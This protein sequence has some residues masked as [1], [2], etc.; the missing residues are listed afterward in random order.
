MPISALLFDAHGQDTPLDPHQPLPVPGDDQLLW[1]D[2]EGGEGEPLA[3]LLA[4][5]ALDEDTRALLGS[6]DPRPTLQRR[7]EHVV[8][9]VQAPE[10]DF[11]HYRP[12]PLRILAGRNMVFTAHEGPVSFLVDF[13]DHLDHDTQFGKLDSAA[14][15]AVLLNRH[16]ES[17]FTLL[18]SLEGHVD[19]LDE[20][21]LHAADSRRNLTTLVGLRR[22]VG[23]LRRLLS[24]HRMVYAGLASPDFVIFMGDQPEA[25]LTRLYEQYERAQE[26]ISHTRDMMLGSFDLYMSSTAQRTNEIMRALTLATV[27][28]GIIAAVAGL[29]GM[30]FQADIFTAGNTGFRDVLIF[31]GA[32]IVLVTTVGRWRGWL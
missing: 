14:F 9:S 26:A 27:T 28:L 31:S 21:I 20:N 6:D 2:L 4:T 29:M 19:H 5:L 15:L 8:L 7:A 18:S 10:K 30:N 11:H 12:A 22:R 1:V 3:G 13:R 24:T 23:E 32:L 16:L 25:L 17:Y